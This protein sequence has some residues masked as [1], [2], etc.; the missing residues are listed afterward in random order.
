MN[1]ENKSSV[2]KSKVPI[3]LQA[4][5]KKRDIK[6]IN[7]IQSTGMTEVFKPKK[8]KKSATTSR[9]GGMR[10]APRRGRGH[11]LLVVADL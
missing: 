4:W 5:A 8:N 1:Y 7:V 10:Q 3:G 11:A 6:I 2:N 9:A